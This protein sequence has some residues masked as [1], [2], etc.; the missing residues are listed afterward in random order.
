MNNSLAIEARSAEYWP[1]SGSDTH[2]YPAERKEDD[3]PDGGGHNL[4]QKLGHKIAEYWT[5]AL[6]GLKRI[7]AGLQYFSGY[8]RY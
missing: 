6:H 4:R 2:S 8:G 1:G 3:D 5:Q 7:I